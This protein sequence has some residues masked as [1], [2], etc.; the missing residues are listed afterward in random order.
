MLRSSFVRLVALALA[1]SALPLAPA[2]AQAD[3]LAAIR[4]TGVL[5]VGLTGDYKP[6]SFFDPVTAAWSG[7]DVDAAH[8]LATSLGTKLEIVKTEWPKMTAD[9]TTGKF[10]IAMGGVSRSRDRSEAG[11]LTQAYVSDGKVALIRAADRARF[12]TLADFNV[13][14]VR[15]AVNP[16]GTNQQFVDASVKGATVT[17]LEKNLS[18]PPL[19]SN[20]TYDVMFTDGVEAAYYAQLD[21]KLAVMNA[22]TPFTNIEKVY[23]VAKESATLLAY[24]DAWMSARER[25]GTFT[26]LRTRYIGSN[27]NA[28]KR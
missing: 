10:D 4:S 12:A 5:R 7:L 14:S 19:V 13:P 18:I 17:V 16:G 22:A 21:P 9:V 1:L 15:V 25:D 23:Y 27:L 11:L 24:V 26:A 28:P 2:L 6:F 20:G 3:R 8:A